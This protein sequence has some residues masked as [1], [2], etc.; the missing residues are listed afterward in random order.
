MA[1][2]TP[3]IL[4][5]G[6]LSMLDLIMT[7]KWDPTKGLKIAVGTVAAAFV[8]AGADKALPGFGT[9]L[10]VV[11]LVAVIYTSGGRLATKII[12]HTEGFGAR[13]G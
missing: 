4:T 7:E 8:S 3:I 1:A 12:P 11:L 6:A 13:T 10:A 9:G 2:S 5:A